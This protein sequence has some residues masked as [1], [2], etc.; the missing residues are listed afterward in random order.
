MSLYLTR[1]YPPSVHTVDRIVPTMALRTTPASNGRIVRCAESLEGI[2]L[3]DEA[4]SHVQ[5]CSSPH[6]PAVSRPDPGPSVAP[7]AKLQTGRR[8]KQALRSPLKDCNE[9]RSRC[10]GLLTRCCETVEIY[11][12]AVPNIGCLSSS[13]CAPA[14]YFTIARGIISQRSSSVVW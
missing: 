11:S 1:M 14:L 3:D 13:G 8:R 7:R 5:Y 9:P 12:P 10:C 2:R 4:C 6:G